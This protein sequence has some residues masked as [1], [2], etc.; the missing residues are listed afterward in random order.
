[1]KV[2]DASAMIDVI[3][4]SPRADRLLAVFDDDL[5]APDLLVPE[6]LGFL[7][8]TAA[9]GSLHDADQLA[10]A[11][12]QA[13]IEYLHTWPYTERMWSWRHNMSPYDASYVALAEDLGATLVTSDLRLAKAAAGVVKVISF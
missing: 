5:F 9:A 2:V 6:V 13:P 8:R 11:L 1:M 4:G 3:T 7:R 10:T 12:Q